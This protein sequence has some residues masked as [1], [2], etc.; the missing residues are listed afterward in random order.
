MEYGELHMTKNASRA[1][2]FEATSVNKVCHKTSFVG[3]F[4]IARLEL[5]IEVLLRADVVRSR[6]GGR[7]PID[8]CYENGIHRTDGSLKT[9]S[10]VEFIGTLLPK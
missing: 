6:M 9:I 5:A 3:R 4:V 2:A 10:E 8:K 7:D 1:F